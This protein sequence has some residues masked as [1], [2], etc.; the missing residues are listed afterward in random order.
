MMQKARPG[1]AERADEVGSLAAAT[2]L[3][4]IFAAGAFL[5]ALPE[6]AGIIRQ[7]RRLP[8]RTGKE[9]VR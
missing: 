2:E 6:A 3:Y 9:G 7:L 5:L 8:P 1:K 4:W